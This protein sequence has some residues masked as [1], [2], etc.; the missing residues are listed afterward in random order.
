MFLG[1]TKPRYS[2]V[3]PCL[4]RLLTSLLM[5]AS[6]VE[7]TRA[8]AHEAI[9]VRVDKDVGPYHL[10]V[11]TTPVDQT[12]SLPLTVILT[13]PQNE[14][15][16]EAAGTP[17]LGAAITATFQLQ[18]AAPLVVTVPPEAGL[19][20]FGYYERWV[21]LASAGRWQITVA[22]QGP[23]GAAT[24]SFPLTYNLPPPDLSWALWVAIGLPLLILIAIFL[25]ILRHTRATGDVP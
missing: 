15:P 24:T 13:T 14:P 23:N 20:E 10:V 9:T 12:G 3:S 6:F 5:L 8:A 17:V 2:G 25:I 22:V 16:R 21:T 4:R 11:G 18:E 19:A 7:V 1:R